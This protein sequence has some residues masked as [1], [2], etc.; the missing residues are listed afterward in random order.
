MAKKIRQHTPHQCPNTSH[1]VYNL[2]LH[3]RVSCGPSTSSEGGLRGGGCGPAYAGEEAVLGQDCYGVYEEDGYYFWGVSAWVE[4][5]KR[6]DCELSMVA[7]METY[8]GRGRRGRMWELG[9][10]FVQDDGKN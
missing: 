3:A 5:M 7:L 8:F 1:Q 2:R 6:G 10:W 9:P 4:G